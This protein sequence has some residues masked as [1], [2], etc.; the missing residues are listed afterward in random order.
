MSRPHSTE[1]TSASGQPPLA[2]ESLLDPLGRALAQGHVLLEAPTGSGKSTLVPIALLDADW[3]RGQRILLLQPRRPAARMIATR[4]ALLLGEPVGRRVGFQ[5]RFERQI[6][7]E[8]R[9]E[10]ITEGILTRRLQS[11]PLLDGVGLLI[12]DEFH[13]RSLHTDLA[14]AL[15]LDSIA[16]ARPDLRLLLMSATLDAHSLDGILVNAT[17]IRGEGRRFPVEIRHLERPPREDLVS[18]V[19]TAARAALEAHRG[20]LLVF[21]PGTRE[22]QE[23]VRRLRALVGDALDVLP[24]HGSLPI[25][26]QA[27]ALTTP[28]S[29]RRRVIVATDIAET[30]LTIPG[31][32]VVIDSGWG[33]RPRFDPGSGLTRLVTEP[34]ARASAEQRAGR[35]GRTAPGICYRLWSQAHEQR[36]PARRTPEILDAD[37]AALVLELRLWGVSDSADLQWIDAPPQPAVEQATAL[38]QRLGALDDRGAITPLGRRMAELPVHPRQAAMLLGAARRARQDAADLCALI[39]ERDPLL[40]VPGQA[41]PADLGLRLQA[42]HTW[43]AQGRAAGADAQRLAAVDRVSRQLERLT[44]DGPPHGVDSTAALLALAYPERIAQRREGTDGRYRLALGSGARLPADDA[45]AIHPFLVIAGLDAA[46][47]DGRILAALPIGEDD[48][49][50]W[51]AKRIQSERILAW[52]TRRE[53][54]SARAIERL[55]ALVLRAQPVPLEPT[56]PTSVILRQQI[57]AQPDRALN[58]NPETLQWIARV[59]LMRRLEP[60]DIWPDVSMETLVATLEHWLEPHLTGMSRLGQ[61]QALDLRPLLAERL[62]WAQR[63]RLDQEAPLTLE[64]PAGRPRRLEYRIGQAPILAVPLQELFGLTETPRICSGRVPVLLHLLSPARRPIQV[65]QDLAGFWATGY[66]EVRKELRGRYPKH[67]W[68]ED[69]T[70]PLPVLHRPSGRHR[71]Q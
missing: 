9:I 25:D 39:S 59:A 69:P 70:R 45:L 23:C 3:L 19:I 33:R 4:L 6:G 28:E 60:Q 7:S 30:S 13:E 68:P 36:R 35:A 57:T 34:I 61:T 50:R 52:D 14:L 41:R 48:L 31:I 12:F 53:A 49:R 18:G 54:V 10:V 20:D 71:V 65:T 58:W 1:P 37:L 63:R 46:G 24:L 67:A 42:L 11:D 64:T 47:P 29:G 40:D 56:D 32:D 22:I 38:L 16:G 44:R 62:G 51:F 27:L 21:L 55:E 17:R 66:A 8:C 43:R 5:I 15:A 2:I 26:A